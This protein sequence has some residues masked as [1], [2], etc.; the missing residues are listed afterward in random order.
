MKGILIEVAHRP[1]HDPAIVPD[2]RIRELPELLGGVV[3]FHVMAARTGCA[4]RG[5]EH[6]GTATFRTIPSNAMI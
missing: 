2:A 3:R 4:I 5:S 1:E 6:H